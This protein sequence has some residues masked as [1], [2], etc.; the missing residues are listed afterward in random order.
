MHGDRWA[1][2]S[3]RNPLTRRLAHVNYCILLLLRPKHWVRPRDGG[4]GRPA[5]FGGQIIGFAI[6]S[7][8]PTNRVNE[9]PVRSENST[10]SSVTSIREKD[11]FYVPRVR[12]AFR[13]CGPVPPN[14]NDALTAYAD[15][16]W[17]FR[18][19]V[20]FENTDY[21]EKRTPRDGRGRY[22]TT[23]TRNA[24]TTTRTYDTHDTDTLTTDRPIGYDCAGQLGNGTESVPS[25]SM[26]MW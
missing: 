25:T 2:R 9:A 8:T 19:P 16:R 10:P 1:G 11:F 24:T 18:I 4:D 22:G 7:R 14:A 13:G 26:V 20:T 17:R 6:R 12:H 23:V 21:G 5:R 3:R 15:V